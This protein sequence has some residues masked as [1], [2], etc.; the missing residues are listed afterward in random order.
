MQNT[1]QKPLICETYLFIIVDCSR[2]R[3]QTTHLIILFVNMVTAARFCLRQRPLHILPQFF[4][5]R[6][7]FLRLNYMAYDLSSRAITRTV[8]LLAEHTIHIGHDFWTCAG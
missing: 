1:E 6:D 3:R 5:R 7:D 8:G 2:R 4:H